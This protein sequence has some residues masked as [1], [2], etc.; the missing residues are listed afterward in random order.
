M[1]RNLVR[2]SLLFV[3]LMLTPQMST[4]STSP[5]NVQNTNSSTMMSAQPRRER[6]SRCRTR[7]QR[8]YRN[9]LRDGRDNAGRR[10]SCAV[11]YRN[12]LRRCTRY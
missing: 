12:C 1:K 2:L 9:C 10:R 3:L 8:E 6:N 5:G 4:A 7:C 11:R